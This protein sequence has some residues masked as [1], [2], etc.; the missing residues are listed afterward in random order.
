MTKEQFL[1]ILDY[2]EELYIE[3]EKKQEAFDTYI[4]SISDKSY[5]PV[6]DSKLHVAIELVWI[7][8]Q[9]L[10]EEFNYYFW[11]AKEMTSAECTHKDK[12]YNLKD[13]NEFI[14]WIDD[15]YFPI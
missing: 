9:D 5:S 2:C 10:K 6:L 13:K 4:E 12:E 7:F 8:S 3:D 14:R 15:I 11:E 1:D